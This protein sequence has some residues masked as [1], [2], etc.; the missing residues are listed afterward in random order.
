M[1]CDI[2]RGI[3]RECK[4]GQGGADKVWV[5]SWI[6]RT[7]SQVIIDAKDRLISYPLTVVYPVECESISFN[8]QV[9]RDAGAVRFDQTLSFEVPRVGWDR[10][11]AKW[12]KKRVV[13]IFRDRNGQLR[14]SGLWNGL[15]VGYS[16]QTGQGKSDRNGYI[17]TLTGQERDQAYFLLDLEDPGFQPYEPP[18]YPSFEGYNFSRLWMPFLTDVGLQANYAVVDNTVSQKDI[19]IPWGADGVADYSNLGSFAPGNLYFRDII[20]QITGYK[21]AA[22]REGANDAGQ[23]V[24][25]WDQGSMLPE[26]IAGFPGYHFQGVPVGP[27]VQ[28][29]AIVEMNPGNE[30]TIFVLAN[31]EN[32]GQDAIAFCIGEQ[33]SNFRFEIHISRG[34]QLAVQIIADNTIQIDTDDL[35]DDSAL[36]LYIITMRQDRTVNLWVN[37]VEQ[38]DA[39]AYVGNYSNKNTNI[40]SRIDGGDPLLGFVSGAGIATRVWSDLEIINFSQEIMELFGITP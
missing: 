29:P 18:P 20:C 3:G 36:R 37:G 24:K 35:I 25:A 11:I 28:G 13:A 40:G 14:I 1:N 2:N 6:P 9:A 7:L 39:A 27:G 10:D 19:L 22:F 8:E 33:G 5:F 17:M 15:E 38:L 21:Y 4:D 34:S 32:P 26:T 30:R 16:D 23:W 12:T 31:N